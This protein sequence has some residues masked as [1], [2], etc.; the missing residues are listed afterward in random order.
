MIETVLP[1]RT[2]LAVLALSLL[3]ASPGQAETCSDRAALCRAACT[4]ENVASGAQHGGTVRGCQSSCQSRL[5]SCLRDG[6][7]VHMGSQRFGERQAV[8]KR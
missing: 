6:T 8:D 2:V 4:P 3:P 5:N 7:W 1:F